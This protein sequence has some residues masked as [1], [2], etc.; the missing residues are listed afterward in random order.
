M[1][2]TGYVLRSL[3]MINMRGELNMLIFLESLIENELNQKWESVDSEYDG[4]L[5]VDSRSVDDEFAGLIVKHPENREFTISY[6]THMGR[7]RDTDSILVY[8]DYD[9]IDEDADEEEYYGKMCLFVE[10]FKDDIE[11]I[12]RILDMDTDRIR[13]M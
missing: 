4:P 12:G 8:M 3:T 6:A 1:A 5:K 10:T 2:R 7:K 11:A 9:Y 13:V